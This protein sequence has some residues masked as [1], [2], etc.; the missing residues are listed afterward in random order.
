MCDCYGF[1]VG[2]SF[3]SLSPQGYFQFLIVPLK[4]FRS[5]SEKPSK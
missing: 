1:N 3:S 4:G 2:V 5:R